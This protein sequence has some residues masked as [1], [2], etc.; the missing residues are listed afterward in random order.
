MEIPIEALEP[1]PYQPRGAIDAEQ[2]EELAA[3]IKAHGVLQPLSG[4]GN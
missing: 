1:N 2:V 4:E 3:S